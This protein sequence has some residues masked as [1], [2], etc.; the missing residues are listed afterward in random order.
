MAFSQVLECSWSLR[1]MMLDK[2]FGDVA[3][4]CWP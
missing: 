2:F 1:W 3:S 4:W